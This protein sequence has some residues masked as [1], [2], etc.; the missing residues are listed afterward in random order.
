MENR[1]ALLPLGRGVSPLDASLFFSY[2]SFYAVGQ[3]QDYPL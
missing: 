1:I 3:T 2:T